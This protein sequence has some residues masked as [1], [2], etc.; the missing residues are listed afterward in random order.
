M[1]QKWIEGVGLVQHSEAHSQIK[2]MQEFFK[3]VKD[4]AVTTEAT[5]GYCT[6]DCQVNTDGGIQ[7]S[8]Y[9]D[10]LGRFTGNT[11][12]QTIEVLL[13]SIG[14]TK[15]NDIGIGEICKEFNYPSE[16]LGN[17]VSNNENISDGLTHNQI[18]EDETD[19]TSDIPMDTDEDAE[20]PDTEYDLP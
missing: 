10:T 12:E 14:S 5:I 4:I 16:M 15:R 9:V 8:C 3:R 2:T 13:Q 18:H 19:K 1:E 6:V 20:K 11:P 17:S 7:F